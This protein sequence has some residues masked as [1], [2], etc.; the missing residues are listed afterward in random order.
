MGEVLPPSVAGQLDW[1]IFLDRS[2]VES[3]AN[4]AAATG[5]CL[6]PRGVDA[7]KAVGVDVF[8]VGGNVQLV[9]LV[10]ARMGT[11]WAAGPG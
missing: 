3:Y 1:H 9:S 5:R 10:A 4:G 7:K 6:L 8:A 2:V 11:M